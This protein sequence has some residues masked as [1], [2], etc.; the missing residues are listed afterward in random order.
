VVCFLPPRCSLSL[1]CLPGYM[2][3]VHSCSDSGD[4][5]SDENSCWPQSNPDYVGVLV[6]CV[7]ACR[8]VCV[9]MCTCVSCVHHGCECVFVCLLSRNMVCCGPHPWIIDCESP[10]LWL[11][12]MCVLCVRIARVFCGH[13][14]TTSLGCSHLCAHVLVHNVVFHFFFYQLHGGGVCG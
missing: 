13:V 5:S 14:R 9:P 2:V 7:S 4:L 12:V 1:T 3:L 10:S 8:F 6:C 11:C